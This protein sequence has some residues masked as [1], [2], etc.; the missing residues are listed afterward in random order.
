MPASIASR[1]SGTWTASGA[2]HQQ[3]VR[4]ASR[5][6][7]RPASAKAGARA[8]RRGLRRGWPASGSASPDDRDRL[9]DRLQPADRRDPFRL[10][11]AAAAGDRDRQRTLR[12]AFGLVADVV[13]VA[14]AE[15]GVEGR[16]AEVDLRVGGSSR[17]RPPREI[18]LR[19][20]PQRQRQQDRAALDQEELRVA[21]LQAESPLLRMARNEHADRRVA[22]PAGA[23]AERCAADDHGDDGVELEPEAGGRR[24]GAEPAEH[25][26]HAGRG[27]QRHEDEHRE[28]QPLLVDARL[29]Q[30][31]RI[32]AE[33]IDAHADRQPREDQPAGQEGQ[34]R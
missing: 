14:A 15:G 17:R 9:A 19:K 1:A 28:A 16:V 33:R 25:D 30:H 2:E 3:Q 8:E 13:D 24:G 5:R 22:Q 34:R 6:A 11:N 27:E 18:R 26:D 29:A 20:R 10:R 12:R 21:H 23:A 31:P 7:G 32:A 4:P